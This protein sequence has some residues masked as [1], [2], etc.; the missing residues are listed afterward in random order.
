LRR[1]VDRSV[2]TRDAFSGRT[3]IGAPPSRGFWYESSREIAAGPGD[4]VC[5]P[6]DL[7]VKPDVEVWDLRP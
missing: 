4:R 5:E 1:A 3:T 2:H 7:V 6:P